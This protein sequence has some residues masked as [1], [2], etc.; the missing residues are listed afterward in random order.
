[1][2]EQLSANFR[3]HEGANYSSPVRKVL[4][5]EHYDGPVDGVLQCADGQVYRFDLLA[6]EEETQDVRVFGLAPL[7]RPAWERLIALC[8]DCETPRWPIW[9]FRWQEQLRQP[10]EDI[11][12]QSGAMEWIIAT[13]DLLGEIL[14]IKAIHLEE[15]ARIGNWGAFLG[16]AQELPAR[17]SR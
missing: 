14:R 7:A 6:W 17:A 11:L 12:R 9:A 5:F 15:L 13:E 8:T 16:L 1:M 10:I 4:A 2:N 3:W